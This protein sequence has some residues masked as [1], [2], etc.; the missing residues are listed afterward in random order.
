MKIK[1]LITTLLISFILG[2]GV[3]VVTHKVHANPNFFVTMSAGN[4]SSTATATSTLK[5]LT[6]GT[7]TTTLTFDAQTGTTQ[8][9]DSA[10]LFLQFTG[11][12]TPF[13]QQAT[14]TYNIAL[15]RSH[16]GIDYY[17]DTEFGNIATTTFSYDIST[18][19]LYKINLINATST[20]NGLVSTSTPVTRVIDVLTPTRFVRAVITIPQGSSNG[21]VWAQFVGKRQTGY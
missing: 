17:Q 2:L 13:T 9:L 15:E 18:S 7:G 4:P 19:G 16:D 14:T 10:V 21:A 6:A 11:S 20:L 12:S 5:F 1:L 8:A 3:S